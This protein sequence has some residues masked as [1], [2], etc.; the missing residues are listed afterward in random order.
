MVINTLSV[1][2]ISTNMLK[3]GYVGKSIKSAWARE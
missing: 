1:D 3:Y 2:K